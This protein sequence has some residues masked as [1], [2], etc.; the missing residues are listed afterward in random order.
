[1]RRMDATFRAEAGAEKREAKGDDSKLCANDASMLRCTKEP[2]RIT[3][4]HPAGRAGGGQSTRIFAKEDN[5][6]QRAGGRWVCSS[7]ACQ[8]V[9]AS[10]TSW[11]LRGA[12]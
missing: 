4:Q 2:P 3:D 6:C 10:Q 9:P 11:S 7:V 1:M 8:A 12:V 5:A